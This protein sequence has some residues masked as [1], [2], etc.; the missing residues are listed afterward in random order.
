MNGKLKPFKIWE[1]TLGGNVIKHIFAKPNE[2][3]AHNLTG[4]PVD[5]MADIA[6]AAKAIQAT[7][8]TT[9]VISLGKAGALVV[10]GEQV[11]QVESPVIKESNPIGAGDSMVGGLVWGL[12]N[13]LP[14]TEAVA[15]GIA[16]GAATASLPGTTV[17]NKPLIDSLHPQVKQHRMG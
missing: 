1:L 12:S 2:A 13:G 4:M 8:V 14:I 3:E 11:W 10:D 16:C 17:G 9:V 7:G 6:A 15:W 5:T